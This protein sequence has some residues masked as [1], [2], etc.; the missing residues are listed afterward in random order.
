[1][2][3][4]ET[5]LDHEATR[6]RQ[7]PNQ[8]L[9]IGDS[10]MA[11]V[12]KT[13]NAL[14]PETGYQFGTIAVAGTTPRCWYY[15]LRAADPNANQYRAIVIGIESYNDDE[16]LEDYAERESDLNYVLHRLE[17]RDLKEF[18]QSYRDPQRQW[19]AA[20]GIAFKGLIYKRDLQD[21]L[22]TS[23][24]ARAYRRAKLARFA[25]LVLR[26]P[27]GRQNAHGPESRLAESD[28]RR[29]RPELRRRWKLALRR[30]TRW[31]TAAAD[32]DG[33]RRT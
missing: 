28:N 30:S 11:L 31:A 33:I 21:F 9:G 32:R 13:A 12:A 3:Y 27:R 4:V 7:G 8:V 29:E 1:M 22:L 26:L 20:T 6:V 23:S 18:S 16:L 5:V 10:R 14:T 2:G 15:M 25:H 17:L 19:R 24:P